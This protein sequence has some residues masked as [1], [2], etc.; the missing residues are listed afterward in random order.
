MREQ[1]TRINR[2]VWR[3]KDEVKGR[4]KSERI[5]GMK[6]AIMIITK[7]ITTFYCLLCANTR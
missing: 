6:R 4:K 1:A 5:R 3:R 7:Y 2:E